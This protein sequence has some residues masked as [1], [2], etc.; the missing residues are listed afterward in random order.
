MLMEKR[1]PLGRGIGPL[2]DYEVLSPQMD[3]EHTEEALLCRNCERKV[4][5]FGSAVDDSEKGLFCNRE[6]MWSSVFG[7]LKKKK[8]VEERRRHGKREQNKETIR[9]QLGPSLMDLEKMRAVEDLEDDEYDLNA[10]FV[11]HALMAQS[12]TLLNRA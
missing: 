11:Y 12:Y 5:D 2:D 6:C 9:R 4:V 10:M 7:G 8:K 1:M 3:D